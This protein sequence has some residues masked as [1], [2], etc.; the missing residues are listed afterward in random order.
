MYKS[1]KK[2]SL[3][4]KIISEI[5]LLISDK[6]KSIVDI[7]DTIKNDDLTAESYFI[8]IASHLGVTEEHRKTMRFEC[9]LESEF[10]TDGE[11]RNLIQTIGHSN[12]KKIYK[13]LQK[14]YDDYKNRH[15]NIKNIKQTVQKQQKLARQLAQSIS[16]SNLNNYFDE[17]ISPFYGIIARHSFN[18]A[19]IEMLESFPNNHSQDESDKAALGIYFSMDGDSSI[20]ALSAS[21]DDYADKLQEFFTNDYFNRIKN[22]YSYKNINFKEYVKSTVFK[23]L[24]QY[25]PHDSNPN[26]ETAL[27]SNLILGLKEEDKIKPNDISQKNR[28][29]RKKYNSSPYGF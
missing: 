8:N 22:E 24:K 19:V 20:R 7:K 23:I 13:R 11:I 3:F 17:D 29:T 16:E 9:G 25:W 12:W 4:S 1:T 15:K 14:L 26:K 28:N 10:D 5:K 27:I 6:N 18:S 21:L 2:M